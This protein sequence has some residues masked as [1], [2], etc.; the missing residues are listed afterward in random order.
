M[1]NQTFTSDNSII[2]S[3]KRLERAGSEASAATAKLREAAR[4]VAQKIV[5]ICPADAVGVELPRGYRVMSVHSNIAS[6]YYLVVPG[7]GDADEDGWGE[8][9]R[10]LDVLSDHYQHRD[11]NSPVNAATR[12]DVLQFAA[13]IAN[14]LLAEIAAWLEARTG[15]SE[16]ATAQLLASQP[17][18]DFGLPSVVSDEEPLS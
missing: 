10:M 6:E 4:E 8:S 16:K 17:D 9:A 11:F 15:E 14:G 3:L 2:N 18:N 7:T 12:G 1:S 13:D 5:D